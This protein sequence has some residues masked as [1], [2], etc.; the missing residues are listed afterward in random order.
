MIELPNPPQATSNETRRVE[1]EVKSPAGARGT[2]RLP[3]YALYYVCEGAKGQCL[4]RR[5][6]VP[7]ELIAQP[8]DD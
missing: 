1:F 2:T 8:P 7:L 5:Q 6:D 3:A 4:Y